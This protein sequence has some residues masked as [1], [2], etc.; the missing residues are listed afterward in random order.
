MRADRLVATLLL[1]QA[2]GHV[3]APE[4]AAEL[5]VSVATARR[6]LESLST[7]G[8]P[9]YAQRGRGGG[10]ALLGGGRT[11]L[12]GLSGPEVRALFLLLG[13]ASSADPQVRG[14]LRKLVRALPASFREQASAAGAALVVDPSRWG[15]APPPERA[16][17]AGGADAD[18]R[19]VLEDGVV[20]RRRVSFAYVDGRGRTDPQR[21]TVD[22][23]GLVE[24][25]GT[26]Y[27]VAGTATG[28]RTF[29]VARMQDVQVTD[30]PAQRPVD[31]DLVAEWAAARAQVEELRARVSAD[32]LV[33]PWAL[34]PLG[35]VLG[36]HLSP[37]EVQPD[38][39]T[40]A[41][42]TSDTATMLAR[43]LA[44]WHDAVEVL[45]P[46]D[47]RAA[48]AAIGANLADRYGTPTTDR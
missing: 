41:T 29:R 30:E 21:R 46:P 12:S 25:A 43:R 34:A 5:E 48:L 31:L 10:W 3:T 9:V 8:L 11:D 24:K 27:L 22:P 44:G 6:D 26:W 13:P 15:A 37:G 16:G 23:W 42:V 17:A 35:D 38:G 7:A 20:A 45:G 40:R 19:A 36:R 18:A 39:R 2:R 14:A 47:V 4:V 1:L 33:E 32:V 28:R